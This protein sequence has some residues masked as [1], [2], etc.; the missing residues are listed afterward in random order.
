MIEE[1]VS[2]GRVMGSGM[3]ALADW[4]AS[5][6]PNPALSMETITMTV[7]GLPNMDPRVTIYDADN[8]IIA[9]KVSMTE[10]ITSPGLYTYD[11]VAD[12]R[13]PA[14]K[15]YT[16]RVEDDRS[17][18]RVVGTGMVSRAE[19]RGV[20]TPD[21]AFSM[22]VITFTV[23][24]LAGMSPKISV[25]GD[26]NKEI[27]AAQPMKASSTSGVYT[28]EVTADSRF[29][30]GKSYT[31]LVE[32]PISGGR[33]L[34]TGLVA[35]GDWQA[36][37]TPDPVLSGD[38][39]TLTVQG[40]AKMDPRVTI[41]DHQENRI[42]EA[43]EMTES[44]IAPG[45]YTYQIKAD[46]AFTAGKAYTYVVEETLSG[47]RVMGSGMVE[48]MGL[49]TIAG[50]AAAAPSAERIAR[51]AL[52]SIQAIEAVVTSSDNIHI[53]FAL[54]DL[55][56][57]VEAIPNALAKDGPS[58]RLAGMVNEMSTRLSA[59]AGDQGLDL[60]TLLEGAI[61][62]SATIK[63][64]R[65][66]ADNINAVIDILMQ[67][68][69]AKFGGKDEPV[70]STSLHVG[71]VRF[72]IVAVNPSPTRTQTIEV[73]NYLPQEVTPKDVMDSGGLTL[74]YDIDKSL[75]YVYASG[76]ELAPGEVRVF[77]VEV[78]DIWSIP[79][80]E[81]DEVRSRVETILRLLGPTEYYD[82]AKQIGD[83]INIRLDE[84][85]ASQS[86]EALSRAVYI[87]NYRNNVRTLE[88]IKEDIARMEKMLVTAGGP[89]APEML[90]DA[91]VRSDSPSETMT[92]LI[93]FIIL[94]FI[95]LLAAV[96]FLTWNRHAQSAKEDILAAKNAAFP[97]GEKEKE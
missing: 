91:K 90:A 59:L 93:I 68:F 92:W 95:G 41:Y 36:V 23:Q 11:I 1:P 66:K 79:E 52:D 65:G 60:A 29:T 80:E 27:V 28:Y 62:G 3:V 71:S 34:G 61:S 75:Y 13:F 85:I 42:V 57:S 67:L 5:V 86:D 19:W 2:K 48:S 77:E 55:K 51:Q 25:Y 50:L 63:D 72:R 16:Y 33:V 89:Q 6:T 73:K 7:Q 14:G 20:I 76:V 94:I 9:E 32:E 46:K 96:L 8:K 18:G 39:I 69:E 49:T 35:R 22:D 82:S 37:V 53:A 56:E 70:V 26:G 97:E 58:E 21:P 74:E 83:T 81:I 84:I 40:L 10:S 15:A 88:L 87:G 45:L 17:L 31:Y 38:T 24:G 44:E 4:K 12:G 78:E 64:I 30:A 47:G 54:R 43:E